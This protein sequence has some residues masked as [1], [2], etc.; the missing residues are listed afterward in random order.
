MTPPTDPTNDTLPHTVTSGTTDGRSGN[1]DG[2]FDSG[3]MDTGDTFE[4]TFDTEGTF[5]YYCT[6]HPW[7]QG[8]VTVVAS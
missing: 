1:P 6:P 7:M 3:N 4:F 8:T 5:P 2:D